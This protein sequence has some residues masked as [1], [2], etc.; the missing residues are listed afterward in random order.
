[1]RCEALR[2]IGFDMQSIDSGSLWRSASYLRR[3][4]DQHR[5]HSATVDRFNERVLSLVRQTSPA[6]VWAEKQEYL[7]ADVLNE[8]RQ[9]GVLTIHYNPDPY[10]ALAW[11]QTAHTDAC[12]AAFD[13]LVVTKR[14]ELAEY[15]AKNSGQ[16]L[17]SPL[18]Y[19]RVGHRPTVGPVAGFQADVS[20]VGGWEPARE[21]LILGAREVGRIIKVWGYGWRHAQQARLNPLRAVRLG[22]LTTVQRPYFG[23]SRP[24]L[25]EIVQPGEGAHGE[26][27]ENN[28]SAAVA[29]ASVSLGF[30]REI[31]P[32]Q[33]T[34][35]SF[36][37][38]AMR[39]FLLGH[40]SDEHLEFFTEGVEAEY[41]D[42][43]EEF[44][45]KLSFY[46]THP[47]ARTSVANFGYE[48]CMTS[49]Y[50][51]DDRLKS[52]MLRIGMLET[53]LQ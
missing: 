29:S 25:R 33:H 24:E 52:V 39:G 9:L 44:F 26:I 35:R 30:L 34:T 15:A 23:P 13:I 12:L 28:Y 31:C 50:S 27:Y 1:M 2:R 21:R 3:Q 10:Y 46:L 19:D 38:P 8:I 11:K 6:F 48:R 49:G 17:Y 41:F 45:D 42:S 22:R 51:Y 37:I 5:R 32:D 14:Y 36:E 16:V 47:E 7:S 40:R 4:M 43:D 20:F 18:G 53:A